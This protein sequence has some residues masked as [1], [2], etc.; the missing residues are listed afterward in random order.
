MYFSTCKNLYHYN[1]IISFPEE[2]SVRVK[3]RE[4][5]EGVT[6]ED[7]NIGRGPHDLNGEEGQTM[8]TFNMEG[9]WARSSRPMRR[10]TNEYA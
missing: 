2:S 9:F 7:R 1:E 3:V 8:S 10:A 5:G 4:D 6:E